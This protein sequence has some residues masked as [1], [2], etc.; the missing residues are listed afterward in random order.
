M[1]KSL[2]LVL[3]LSVFLVLYNQAAG[4]EILPQV[5]TEVFIAK[6]KY[7]SIVEAR[8]GNDKTNWQDSAKQAALQQ[9]GKMDASHVVWDS[10][11]KGS[12]SSGIAIGRAYNCDNNE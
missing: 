1:S 3:L 6:C 10:M 8:S 7:I 5:V 9:A 2:S 12:V 11:I 4:A